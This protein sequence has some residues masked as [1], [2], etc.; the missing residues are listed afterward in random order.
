MDTKYCRKCYTF[1][2]SIDFYKTKVKTYLDGRI[3]ICKNCNKKQSPKE[4]IIPSFKVET[5]KFILSFE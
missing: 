1:L 3:N 5:G 4:K 2:P